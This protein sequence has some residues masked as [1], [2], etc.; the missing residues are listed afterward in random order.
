VGAG[1]DQRSE[2]S[3]QTGACSH[4][5]PPCSWSPSWWRAYAGDESGEALSGAGEGGGP[6]SSGGAGPNEGAK[7]MRVAQSSA[8]PDGM[9]AWSSAA[10]GPCG[11]GPSGEGAFGTEASAAG[12]PAAPVPAV[13][14][15]FPTPSAARNRKAW[16]PSAFGPTRR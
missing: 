15:G 14:T 5:S 13:G 3:A 4:S 11:A 9:G 1:G 8:G 2:T 16:G 12:E 6:L 10:S 7:W